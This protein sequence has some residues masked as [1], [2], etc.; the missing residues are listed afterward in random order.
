METYQ[1]MKEWT[2]E[3]SPASFD[4]L[5]VGSYPYSAAR[6]VI[7]ARDSL[8]ALTLQDDFSVVGGGRPFPYRVIWTRPELNP[9]NLVRAVEAERPKKFAESIAERETL[10][11][12]AMRRKSTK[13]AD[14]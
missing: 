12:L 7:R 13:R 1:S 6:R 2:I 8:L 11:E 3:H 9:E 5:R 4:S 14:R 10:V